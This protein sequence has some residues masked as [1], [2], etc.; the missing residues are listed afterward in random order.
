[1]RSSGPGHRLPTLRA[2]RDPWDDRSC[3]PFEPAEQEIEAESGILV[4]A[5]SE[6]WAEPVTV[7][8][9]PYPERDE[10][11]ADTAPEPTGQLCGPAGSTQVR[12]VPGGKRWLGSTAGQAGPEFPVRLL[13]AVGETPG[14][15]G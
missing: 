1:M 3:E 4:T 9:R 15:P 5:S 12:R 13:A 14:L 11:G 2:S 7:E 6:W 8:L 10:E